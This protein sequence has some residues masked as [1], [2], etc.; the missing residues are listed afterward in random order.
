MGGWWSAPGA[1][2][3]EW[4]GGDKGGG[5][6]WVVAYWMKSRPPMPRVGLSWPM[7]VGRDSW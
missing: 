3:E 7:V 4:E 5:G 2:R 1:E 6:W